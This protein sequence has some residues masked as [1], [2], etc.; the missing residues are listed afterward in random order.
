MWFVPIHS[1]RK[2]TLHNKVFNSE[3]PLYHTQLRVYALW[4]LEL[5]GHLTCSFSSA[6]GYNNK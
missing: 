3:N 1:C 6:S 4:R 5:P 2:P